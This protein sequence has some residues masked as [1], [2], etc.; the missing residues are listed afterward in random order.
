MT[1]K[2]SMNKGFARK[3]LIFHP[4]F[5][6]LMDAYFPL[7]L[8]HRVQYD[9]ICEYL[10]TRQSSLSPTKMLSS[11]VLKKKFQSWKRMLP[12]KYKL[13]RTQKNMCLGILRI[14]YFHPKVKR[15][16]VKEI[17]L[18]LT[19][20]SMPLNCKCSLFKRELVIIK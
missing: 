9:S 16:L 2:E 15:L 4:V 12:V 14:N 18:P 5:H 7:I 1:M 6:I 11:Q 8:F 17:C 3:F 20:E 19:L 13:A 10:S